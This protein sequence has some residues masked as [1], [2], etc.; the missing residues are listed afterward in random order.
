MATAENFP[1]MGEQGAVARNSSDS[2][3]KKVDLEKLLKLMVEKNAS[4]LFFTTNAPV[5]IKIE[6]RIMPAT[7][8]RLSNEEV[9][10]LAY[11]VM[12]AKQRDYFE[13]ELEID[14][15]ISRSNLGRFRANVFHQRS[16]VA[17]V[18]R[19]ITHEMPRLDTLNLPDK[20]SELALLRRGLVL[21]VGASGSGKSTTLAAMINHRNETTGSHIVTVEDPIEYLHPNKKS[22]INQRE[23]GL[24]T[25]SFAQALRS[26]VRAA[27]DVVLIGECRDRETMESAL[28]LAGTGHL[29]IATLH[30]NNAPESIDRIINMFPDDRKKL[31]FMDLSQYLRAIISQR[32]VMGRTGRRVAAVE[33]MLNTPHISE[34]ILKGDIA[35]IKEAVQDSSEAGMINFDQ[36]LYQL[37]RE[38]RVDLEEALA[39]ADSRANLEAKISFG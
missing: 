34:L 33:L 1:A 18:L 21:M 13:Q 23:V 36:A 11:K 32:L 14:F 17:M 7:K 25:H 10:R 8:Y 5:E 39:H 31:I 3:R 37:Y 38:G 35:E 28:T 6:G 24:D 29:C 19:Y 4:D 20:L 22:I 2:G 26:V 27:P 30:A 15:A 16:S 9:K 12:D